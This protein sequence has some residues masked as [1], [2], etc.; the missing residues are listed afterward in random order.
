MASGLHRL[1]AKTVTNWKQP[2]MRAD[3]G[4]LYLKTRVGKA[5]AGGGAPTPVKAWVFVYFSPG[6]REMGLGSVKAVD[7]VTARRRAAEAR[8]LV[9]AGIDPIAERAR[10]AKLRAEA[11]NPKPLTTFGSFADAYV[12]G[13]ARD[14][15]TLNNWR[16]T[17]QVYCRPIRDVPIAHVGVDEVV[18]VVRPLMKT[19][20]VSGEKAVTYIRKIL[21][22]AKIAGHR[23]GDN[24]A[25]WVDNLDQIILDKPKPLSA[26]GHHMALSWK[27]MPTFMADLRLRAGVGARALEF[28]ILTAMRATEVTDARW[29][30]IDFD[31]RV[32]TVPASRMK[33]KILHRVALSSDAVD[34]LTA[35]L[36]VDDRASDGFLFPGAVSR[37]HVDAMTLTAVLR[38]MNVKDRSTVHGFRSSFRDWVGEATE[39]DSSLAE[40]ALAHKVGNEVE[41]AY[42]RGDALR[43]RFDLMNAWADFCSGR[44]LLTLR[45]A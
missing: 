12:D 1:T 35:L 11:A 29:E 33:M 10:L 42:R 15:K 32:W 31:R 9:Q 24:P 2:G 40:I 3:G 4:G 23:T 17:V 20:P 34:L 19:R 30:E 25:V 45:A 5:P 28:L 7:L 16:R 22:S 21:A 26:R 44:L 27:E 8:T 13:L 6:R 14:P 37:D 41:Q 43:K 39:F 36:Q 38:R 18:S